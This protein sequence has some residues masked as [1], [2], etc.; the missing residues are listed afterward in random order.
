MT[1]AFPLSW[2]SGWPRRQG[3]QDSDR[4]FNGPTYRWDRVYQGL[5]REV[6]KIGGTN[7]VVSSNQPVRAD[8]LPYAQT[9]NIPDTGV[10]VYFVR[11]GKQ[12][13]MAQD[14]FWSVIGNMRSLTM[15]IEGL[16]QMER[17]G[18]AIMMERAF[19]GFAALPAP[20]R[21]WDVLGVPP[22][23]SAEEIESAFRALAKKHHPDNGGDPAQFAEITAARAQVLGAR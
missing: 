13:A 10:A 14:R 15:A 1:V 16:R 5:I 4:L 3:S 8:G 11:A 12:M 17:H 9:R 18:G 21:W 22:L 20:K 6:A 2:P 7:I 19:E 23:A